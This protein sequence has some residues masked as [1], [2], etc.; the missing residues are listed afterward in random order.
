MTKPWLERFVR[1]S[2]AIEGIHRDP[3][4]KEVEETDLFLSMNEPIVRDLSNLVWIYTGIKDPLRMEK[5][6]NVRVGDHVAPE[7]GA[8]IYRRL[9]DLLDS[10]RARLMNPYEVHVAYETLHPFLDGNGRSGRALWAW[11]MI[12]STPRHKAQVEHLGFLHTW[13]Y[14]SLENSR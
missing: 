14:Q 12:R 5:G 13:Y 2:N 6:M 9:A 1:E 11:M 8:H 10:A 3:T 7:G 4:E